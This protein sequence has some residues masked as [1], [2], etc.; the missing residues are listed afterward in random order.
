M[1]SH[2][3][4]RLLA[5][6]LSDV[7]RAVTPIDRRIVM[8]DRPFVSIIILNYNGQRFLGNCLSSVLETRYPRFEVVLVDN[9]STDGSLDIA[10]KASAKYG[11]IK[12]VKNQKNL[13]YGPAN[14][15]GFKHAIG[16]YI[17]FLNNDTAVDPEWLTALVDTM[18]TDG[19]IG[20]AQSLILNMDGQRIQAAG[21]LVG[22][23]IICLNSVFEKRKLD[24]DELP[25]VFEIS[26]AQ[27]TSMMIRRDLVREIGLFDARY[28]WFYDDTYLSFKTWL[29]GERVVTVSKSIVYHA[30]GGTAGFDSPFIRRHNTICFVSLIFDVYW[31]FL[32][33]TTALFTFSYN[34]II[35]SLKEVLERKKTTRLWA[36]IYAGCWILRNLKYIWKNRLRYLS[37]A[38]VS[39]EV[40]LSKFIRIRIPTRIYLVPPP[41]KLLP[42]YMLNEIRKCW[43]AL[44]LA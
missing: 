27:G 35:E 18:E 42:Q 4:S 13:G 37:M 8:K 22:D 29:V 12:I 25:D 9:A 2:D 41:V 5:G 10:E 38:K 39:Q 1:S 31:G 40:L 30:G 43:E 26:F 11:K 44:T 28:F 34:L 33:L 17:A 7:H 15:V 36:S 3:I 32:D 20:L 14:N 23:Y 21:W 16:D 6:A 19:T 24:D